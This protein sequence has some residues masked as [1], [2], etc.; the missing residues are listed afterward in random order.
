MTALPSTMFG[1]LLASMF[2]LGFLTLRLAARSRQQ[3]RS[4]ERLTEALRRSHEY[5]EQ[6][7]NKLAQRSDPG[8]G[9]GRVHLH[10]LA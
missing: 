1:L 4:I 2:L 6:Q 10:R 9:Q 8:H 5:A 3:Q 7:K